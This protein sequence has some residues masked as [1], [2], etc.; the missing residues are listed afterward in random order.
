MGELSER[1][2]TLLKERHFAVLATINEDGTPHLTTTWYLLENFNGTDIIL[3]NT[4]VGLL[5][6]RNMRRNPSISV[7]IEDEYRYGTI[8][9]NVAIIDDPKVAQADIYR[10]AF[11]YDGQELALQQMWER[12]SKE[13]RVTLRLK[14]MQVS[15]Y[16]SQ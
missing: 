15:E 12:F 8:S 10:L 1:A 7:C 3:M 11:R 14:V 2:R 13:H 9:G 16:F 6:E 5:K 4:A